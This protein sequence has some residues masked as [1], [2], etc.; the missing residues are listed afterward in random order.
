MAKKKPE[1][2]PGTFMIIALVFFVLAAAV[3]GVTTYLGFDG[4][5]E[6]DKQAKEAQSKEKAAKAQADEQLARRDVLRIATNTDDPQDRE[7]LRGAYKANSAAILEEQKRLTDK[8]G[9]AAMPGGRNVFVWQVGADGEIAPAPNK[10]IPQIARIWADMA[11]DAEQRY[12]TEQAAHQ[13]T[14][15]AKAAADKR[16]EDQKATFDQQVADLTKQMND[17][18]AAMDKAFTALKTEADKKG[19]DFKKAMDDW[20]NSKAQLDDQV[21]ALKGETRVWKDR[22]NQALS[23]DGSDLLNRLQKLD[24]AKLAESMGSVTRKSEP[25]VDVKFNKPMNLVPGQTFVVIASGTSLPSVLEREKELEKRHYEFKSNDPREPFKDNELVKGMIEITTP[26]ARDS[27]QARITFEAQQLRTPITQGD[28][29]FNIAL[30]TGTKE[31]VAFAGIVDLDGDGKPDTENFIRILEKNNLNIDAY[32][33]LKTGEI[34]GKGIRPATRF[35]ILGTDVPLVGN[36]KKMVDQAKSL[37]IPIVDARRF[38]ALVG[39]KPPVN[40]A[41]PLYSSVTLGG[42]GSLAPKD[43]GDVLAPPVP[44]AEDKKDEPKKDKE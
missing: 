5:T 14:L 25:F 8:L 35:L 7:D 29:L 41:P 11:R 33:D 9:G 34:R 16:A 19:L 17:K 40:A 23:Q 39:I 27:A 18:V 28:R 21:L 37:S 4:Q 31:G 30:S 10:T 15:E 6:L 13:K 2:G 26:T 1:S 42:E 38:L 43:Q 20:A 24:P 12:R 36:V 44:K 32:L 3:L 22:Y